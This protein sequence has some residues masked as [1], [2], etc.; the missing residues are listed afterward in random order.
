MSDTRERLLD[1][2]CIV[3]AA[4][5]FRGATTRAIADEAGVNEVTLFRHFPSKADLLVAAFEREV[6]A[7]APDTLQWTGD[8]EGDLVRLVRA[9]W[10]FVAPRGA[11]LATLVSELP[12]HPE[13]RR[14]LAV[15]RRFLEA[16][17]SLLARYQK[18]GQLAPDAPIELFA[19]LLG[20]L[21][22]LAFVR[23][24]TP[25]LPAVEVDPVRHVRRFLH[26]ATHERI[27][28]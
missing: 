14:G 4:R 22:T 23:Q 2:A 28:G 16:G 15:P 27:I 25:I 1:A 19:T 9:Y 13:L 11:F 18:E 20:P 17:V 24:G 5:G 12:R 8:L 26:G 7:F 10:S 21:L 6:S 3:I